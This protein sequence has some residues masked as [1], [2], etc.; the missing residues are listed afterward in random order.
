MKGAYADDIE[1]PVRAVPRRCF[2][3]G[4][5]PLLSASKSP[6]HSGLRRRALI[7][8]GMAQRRRS[9]MGETGALTHRLGELFDI[10]RGPRRHILDPLHI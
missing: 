5:L 9:G 2:I 1:T 7:G 8:N 6:R 10:Q 4:A 3:G